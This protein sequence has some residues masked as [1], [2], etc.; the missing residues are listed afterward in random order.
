MYWTCANNVFLWEYK[1]RSEV[2]VSPLSLEFARNYADGYRTSYA[3]YRFSTAILPPLPSLYTPYVSI[4]LRT[5]LLSFTSTHILDSSFLTCPYSK[6]AV[7]LSIKYDL[8]IM[9]HS[10]VEV[11]AFKY[12]P[13]I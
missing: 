4:F 6:F 11:I 1:T 13:F 9:S 5:L 12:P 8:S 2:E 10:A 7:H 3:I